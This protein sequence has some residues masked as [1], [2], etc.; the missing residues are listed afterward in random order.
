[1]CPL[2]L[3]IQSLVICMGMNGR[4]SSA[5][6]FTSAPKILGFRHLPF[7]DLKP[8]YPC[9]HNP[10]GLLLEMS[11]G[12]FYRGKVT[13]KDPRIILNW[14]L[15]HVFSFC[16]AV[17]AP[18]WYVKIAATIPSV[19]QPVKILCPLYPVT[20]ICVV[21][22]VSTLPAYNE[23]CFCSIPLC[24]NYGWRKIPIIA[25]DSFI[26]DQGIPQ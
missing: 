2:L 4:V 18:V 1:M 11:K 13:G 3:K 8:I 5:S 15:A 14:W 25:V 22:Q 19:M 26:E 16:P 10:P 24:L 17:L 21:V 12:L 7:A 23:L 20:E 9:L 6:V